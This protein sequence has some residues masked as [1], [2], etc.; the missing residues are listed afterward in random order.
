MGR[1][2]NRM[3]ATE[4]RAVARELL[5]IIHELGVLG[6]GLVAANGLSSPIGKMATRL[7]ATG[8]RSDL[9]E[10]RSR[11]DDAWYREGH[12]RTEKNPYY[13][14]HALRPEAIVEQEPAE[15]VH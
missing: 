8:F 5:R 10:L 4:H 7:F 2:K 3:S 12:D 9:Q 11:L 6:E 13:G 1:K 15:T 14:T